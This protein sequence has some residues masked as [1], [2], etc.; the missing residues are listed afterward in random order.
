MPPAPHR[1]T[2][3]VPPPRRRNML[4]CS[5]FSECCTGGTVDV[6]PVQHM[7]EGS[8][9]TRRF[10]TLACTSAA[11][12]GDCRTQSTVR[13]MSGHPVSL[14]RPMRL[15]GNSTPCGSTLAFPKPNWRAASTATRRASGDCSP[16]ARRGRNSRLS[17]PSRTRWARRCGSFP[18]QR[19]H[20]RQRLAAAGSGV[21]PPRRKP[22]TLDAQFTA[23]LADVAAAPPPQFSGGGKW[24]AMHGSMSGFYEIRLSGP[25]REQFRLF[26]LLEKGSSEEIARRGLQRPAIA[27]ITG[28]RKP[29]QTAF[30]GRDYQHVREFANEHRRNYPRVIA[31]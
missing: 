1:A 4:G 30:S 14:P 10:S 28:M 11:G 23:V 15:S 19:R 22:G 31:T 29:W 13:R 2:A 16:Q 26:C 6:S 20:S 7:R 17:L 3:P 24:E 21:S 9:W 5:R 8:P 18:G 27:V 12:R 25:R